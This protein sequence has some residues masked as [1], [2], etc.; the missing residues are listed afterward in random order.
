M[1]QN[2]YKQKIILIK[3]Y[4]NDDNHEALITCNNCKKLVPKTMLCLY[5]GQAI[6]FKNPEKN[7]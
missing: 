4:R 6:L 1:S 2:N 5:C 7:I 3:H